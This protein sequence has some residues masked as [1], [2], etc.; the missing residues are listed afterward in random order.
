MQMDQTPFFQAFGE[1]VTVG[2]QDVTAIVQQQQDDNSSGYGHIEQAT[3]LQVLPA[4]AS[5]FVEDT[6][7]VVRGNTF[8]FITHLRQL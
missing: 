7:V 6:T 2:G 8:K 3:W 4:D 1:S 5:H